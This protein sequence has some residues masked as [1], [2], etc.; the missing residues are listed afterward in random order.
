MT[1]RRDKIKEKKNMK[2]QYT[3][4]ITD[5][6]PKPNYSKVKSKLKDANV[7]DEVEKTLHDQIRFI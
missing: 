4:D 3:L 6:L 1:Y 7:P 2:V 5:N